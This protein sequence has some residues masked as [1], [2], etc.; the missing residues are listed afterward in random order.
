MS[1]SLG[2]Y[3][4]MAAKTETHLSFFEIIVELLPTLFDQIQNKNAAENYKTLNITAYRFQLW[5]TFFYNETHFV[6]LDSNKKL[7]ISSPQIRL[8]LTQV[9][10]ERVAKPI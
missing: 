3:K 7:Q 4:V 10:C 5:K 6:S 2:R 9:V 8:A 1:Q